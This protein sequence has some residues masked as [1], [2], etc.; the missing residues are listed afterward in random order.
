MN[1][2]KK[3]FQKSHDDNTPSLKH[4]KSMTFGLSSQRSARGPRADP[5]KPVYRGKTPL[6]TSTSNK[7]QEYWTSVVRNVACFSRPTATAYPSL[8]RKQ[9]HGATN[10][11]AVAN[12]LQTADS[13]VSEVGSSGQADSH[14]QTYGVFIPPRYSRIAAPDHGQFYWP[15][16]N[17]REFLEEQDPTVISAMITRY[18]IAPCYYPSQGQLRPI[19]FDMEDPSHFRKTLSY[20]IHMAVAQGRPLDARADGRYHRIVDA[21]DPTG[22]VPNVG[23]DWSQQAE[24]Y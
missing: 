6:K 20:F 9:R 13:Q 1:S 21:G 22:I 3:L 15:H 17:Y 12:V 11:Q 19:Q 7:L 16:N 8:T 14:V 10:D 23:A 2:F 18:P 5:L 24:C 4:S